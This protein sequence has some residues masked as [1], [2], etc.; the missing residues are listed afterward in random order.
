[1]ARWR[2]AGPSSRG[3]CDWQAAS[4]CKAPWTS[5]KR[6]R[7]CRRRRRT[8]R[9]RWRGGGGGVRIT[10]G[11]FSIP[12]ASDECLSCRVVDLLCV[13][14]PDYIVSLTGTFGG[15]LCDGYKEGHVD[16]LSECVGGLKSGFAGEIDPSKSPRF[17]A[18]PPIPSSLT[19]SRLDLLANAFLQS[20]SPSNSTTTTLPSA[21]HTGRHATRTPS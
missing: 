2:G 8:R 7:S 1:M 18:S 4:Y 12:P 15:H 11:R 19:F 21:H 13:L 3:R 9:C 16:K 5:W 20:P 10:S 17:L 14:L 6:T